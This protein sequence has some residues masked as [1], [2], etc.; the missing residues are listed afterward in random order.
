MPAASKQ[1]LW[2][3]LSKANC[4]PIRPGPGKYAWLTNMHACR[5]KNCLSKAD[6][7]GRATAKLAWRRQILWCLQNWGSRVVQT[8]LR[9]RS[10]LSLLHSL[11]CSLYGGFVCR[12]GNKPDINCSPPDLAWL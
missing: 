5:D 9:C 2:N 3:C 6:C 1:C 7:L 4:K 8:Y 12:G 11:K 10:R